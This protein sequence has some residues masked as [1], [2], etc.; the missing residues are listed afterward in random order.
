MKSRPILRNVN[1]RFG[2]HPGQETKRMKKQFPCGETVIVKVKGDHFFWEICM[3]Y[4]DYHGICAMYIHE[5]VHFS[6][7]ME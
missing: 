2:F 7:P 1:L 6:L 3:L 5:R 4:H